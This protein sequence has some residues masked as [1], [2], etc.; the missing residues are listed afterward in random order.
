ME[1]SYLFCRTYD[2]N[3]RLESLKVLGVFM[4]KFRKAFIDKT[5]FP[6]DPAK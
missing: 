1:S 2:Y 4:F 3:F 6:I 5:L